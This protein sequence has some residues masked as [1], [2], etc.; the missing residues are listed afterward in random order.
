MKKNNL[1]IILLIVV[2]VIGII[3]PYTFKNQKLS[4]SIKNL[5]SI[6]KSETISVKS[7]KIDYESLEKLQGIINKSGIEDV[8]IETVISDNFGMKI[9]FSSN[10]EASSE[11][12]SNLYDMKKTIYVIN[13]KIY[14]DNTLKS[15]IELVV[16][17]R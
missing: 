2:N 8:N 15:Y 13:S 3:I 7:N 12:I 4:N 14:S 11:L 6:N 10:I 17:N 1:I 16:K 9:N 5:Q